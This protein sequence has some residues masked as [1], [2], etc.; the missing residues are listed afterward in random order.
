MDGSSARAAGFYR[1]A[2][3]AE[4]ENCVA[5]TNPWTLLAQ[6]GDLEAAA[7]LRKT[8]FVNT[9]DVPELGQNLAVVECRQGDKAGAQAVLETV[10]T[11]SPGEKG[12]RTMLAEM[13]SGAERCGAPGLEIKALP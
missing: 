12:A 11:Y 5:G 13:T 1:A 3:T 2:L 4:P 10:L 7:A 8:V 6:A 9:Q